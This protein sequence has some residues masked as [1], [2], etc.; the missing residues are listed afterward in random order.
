MFAKMIT[1][2]KSSNKEKG[3]GVTKAVTIGVTKIFRFVTPV[4]EGEG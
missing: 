4:G 3:G 1:K 2:Y